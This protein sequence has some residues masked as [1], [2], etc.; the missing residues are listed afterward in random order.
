LSRGL[1][2][3]GHSEV[4]LTLKRKGHESRRDYPNEPIR[5]LELLL[6]IIKTGAVVTEGASRIS[7]GTRSSAAS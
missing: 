6:P 1:Q 7:V 2:A 4:I 5:T 3:F